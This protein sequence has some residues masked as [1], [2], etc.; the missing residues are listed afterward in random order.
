MDYAQLVAPKATANSIRAWLN[1]D[2]AP[3]TDIL[4]EAEA[5]IYGKLRVR[6]MKELD[7]GTIDDGDLTL[8]LPDNFIAALSFRRIG[9]SA[10]K[11]AILDSQH[12]ETRNAIDADGVFTE[13]EPTECQIIGDP[14]VAYFNC[15]ADDAYPYRLVY[16]ARKPALSVSNTTN[17]LTSRYPKLLRTACLMAGYDFYDQPDKQAAHEKRLEKLIFEAN[18]EYDMGE[19]GN[20]FETYQEDD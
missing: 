10:G 11:I 2:L 7:T 17:F 19:Q 15:E 18:A 20:V 12:M 16:W 5:Y 3:V 4:T 6:E 8:A 13:S 9:P 14:P 1:W